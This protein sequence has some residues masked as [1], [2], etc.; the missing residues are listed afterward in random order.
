MKYFPFDGNA[1][2]SGCSVT[3]S[4]GNHSK[5]L[6]FLSQNIYYYYQ[7]YGYYQKDTVRQELKHRYTVQYNTH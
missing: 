2:F 7:K 6:F 1:E 5:T 4:L 3:L